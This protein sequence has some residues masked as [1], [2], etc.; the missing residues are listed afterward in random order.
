MTAVN[1]QSH[2][3]QNDRLNRQP[4]ADLFEKIAD[5]S[6]GGSVY[7]I[8]AGFGMGKSFFVGEWC[9]QLEAQKRPYLRFDAWKHDFSTQPLAALLSSIQSQIR[10]D[11]DRLESRAVAGAIKK[12]ASKAAP[13]LLKGGV[14]VT[15]R[16]LSLGAID[17]EIDTIREALV[18]EGVSSADSIT[19]ELLSA[20]SESRYQVDFHEGLKGSFSD[21]ISSILTEDFDRAIVLI[22]ELDRCRPQFVFELLEDIKHILTSENTIFFIFC[23]LDVLESQAS[24]IFGSKEGG[25]KY[26]S[27]FFNLK[28]QL[29]DTNRSQF[30]KNALADAFL[31]T[32]ADRKP[33]FEIGKLP[34]IL[35][36]S[37]LSLRQCIEVAKFTQL[38]DAC[39]RDLLQEGI[40]LCYLLVLREGYPDVYRTHQSAHQ[41]TGLPSRFLDPRQDTFQ[42]ANAVSH[43]LRLDRGTEIDG[44]IERLEHDDTVRVNDPSLYHML[45]HVIKIDRFWRPRETIGDFID[46]I[47]GRIERLG[48]IRM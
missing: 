39:D 36:Q 15:A 28:L 7:L 25:E 3:W 44:L 16:L 47:V 24:K 19:D 43:L 48:S 17:G 38:I 26:L 32:G 46:Q 31:A 4:T 41:G 1:D 11:S 40:L 35:A 6:Q 5:N 23:D 8:H 18:Q 22:D 12:F 27:K 29:P 14:R 9:K 33:P 30:C 13:V 34:D 37:S 20:F 42:M 2:A 10:K 45:R 21:F